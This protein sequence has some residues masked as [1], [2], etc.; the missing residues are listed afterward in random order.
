MHGPVRMVAR[1]MGVFACGM[2][3]I[4]GNGYG[5]HRKM[6]GGA[7]MSCGHTCLP[8]SESDNA[9]NSTNM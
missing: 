9:P 1:G 3:G 8:S 4:W 2:H 5:G 7:R 6:R